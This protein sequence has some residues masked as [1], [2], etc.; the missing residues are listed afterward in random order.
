MATDG[1]TVEELGGTTIAI[2]F[3]YSIHNVALQM[4]L[5]KAGLE[6]VS[7]GKPGSDQVSLVVMAP[8]DMLASLASG[9]VA[10]Y[11]VAE[12]FNAM[13][14]LRGIGRIQ[15]FT[16]DIWKDHACCVLV[17]RDELIERDPDLVARTVH[18]VARAQLLCENDRPR[19]AEILT[20]G[21]RPFLPQPPEAVAAAFENYSIEEYGPTGAIQH[22]EWDIDRVDFQPFPFA[23]FT[24]ELVVRLRSTVAEPPST[25]L[26]SLEPAEVHE[27]L[28]DDTFARKAIGELGGP[29]KFGIP[30][31]FSR[32]EEISV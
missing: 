4:L 12:P 30:E 17:V 13:A 28:V 7:G 14:E 6:A 9:A 16:G 27:E 8:S 18:A 32:R 3:W 26:D 23:S 11:I 5:A 10:G 25:F 2:P 24:E 31:S 19:A 21:D 22:P 1:R 20:S 15:R 29:A